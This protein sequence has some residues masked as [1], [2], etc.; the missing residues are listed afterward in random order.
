VVIPAARDS[1]TDN[2]TAF[3]RSLLLQPI[4]HQ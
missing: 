1:S 3:R 2:G 4:T